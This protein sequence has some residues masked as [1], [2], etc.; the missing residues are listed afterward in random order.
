MVNQEQYELHCI[1]AKK[2]QYGMTAD[3]M[4]IC[5]SNI[6]VDR[7]DSTLG[8]LARKIGISE[9]KMSNMFKLL[10]EIANNDT[11]N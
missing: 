4:Y 11:T 9:A 5:A 2:L 1:N 3:I 8:D 7:K 6:V 10:E